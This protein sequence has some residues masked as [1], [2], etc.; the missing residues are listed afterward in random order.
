MLAQKYVKKGC[1]TYL[2]YVLDTKVSESKIASVPMVCEYLDVFPEEFLWLP[3]IREVQFAI[4]LLQEL[5]NRGFARPSFLPW[6]APVL[7]VKKKDGSM[8]LYIDYHQLNK[9]VTKNKYPLPRIDDLFDQFKGTTV[10]LKINLR[11]GYYQ[12]RVK[13]SDVPKIVFRTRYEHYEFLVMPFGLTIA[14]VIFMDLMNRIF[15]PYLD[16]FVVVFIDDILIYSRDDNCFPNS[17]NVS[18]GSERLDF[19]GILFQRKAYELIRL[20]T[21]G[22]FVKGF[23]MIA[24]MMTRLLQKDSFEKSK[25]LL[26]E[27][28]VLV[29]PESGKEFVIF[30]NASLNEGKVI[31]YASR[32]LKPH[33]KNYLTH[34][35]ELVAIVFTLKIWRHHLFDEKCHIFTDHKSLKYIM[36]QTDLNLQQQKWL[37]LLKDYELIIDYHPGKANV[38]SDA[39]SKKSLFAL[40]LI[41]SN[42]GSLLPE[43]KAKQLFLQQICEAQK[44]DNEVQTKRVQCELTTDLDYQIGSD[45][46]LMF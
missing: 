17:T 18:F 8:R 21:I 3:L 27:A 37:K 30:S 41:L 14:P 43:L 46:C 1:D 10:F 4:E 38:V 42:D 35:L 16:R 44:C 2:A 40:L 36:T 15:R 29:Q 13:D 11:S 5:T 20:L 19:G 24:T 31:A 28:P 23:L 39:L 6:G 9:V 7:F 32:Q 34:D 12:L 45:D 25:A 22:V 33:E 26:T